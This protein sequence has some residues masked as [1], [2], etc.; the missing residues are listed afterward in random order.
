M[1]GAP[2][3]LA[4]TDM[5]N[6]MSGGLSPFFCGPSCCLGFDAAETANNA[7]IIRNESGPD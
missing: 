2:G 6:S 7:L 5:G 3:A 1:R 4:K